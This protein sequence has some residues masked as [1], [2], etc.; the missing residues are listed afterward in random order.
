MPL[1]VSQKIHNTWLEFLFCLFLLCPFPSYIAL[2]RTG[3]THSGLWVSMVEHSFSECSGSAQTFSMGFRSEFC[4]GHFSAAA[5]LSL[6]QFVTTLEVWSG[7]LYC[8]KARLWVMS[9]LSKFELSGWYLKVLLRYLY[10]VL[11]LHDP[12]YCLKCTK[13]NTLQHDAT[14]LMLHSWY[15]V[16]QIKSILLL[17]T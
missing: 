8:W 11:L 14:T 4:D 3:V 7:S 9:Q 6:I 12:I 16:V 10:I 2:I 13:Q 17:H 5:L 15:G 1:V